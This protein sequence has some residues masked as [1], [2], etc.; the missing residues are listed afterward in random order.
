MIEK[1]SVAEND[2]EQQRYKNVKKNLITLKKVYQE[3]KSKIQP[4]KP[5]F[6]SSASIR[7]TI[8]VYGEPSVNF[9]SSKNKFSY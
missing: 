6:I 1:V 7:S 4:V 9:I 5:T 2:F 3:T 8:F